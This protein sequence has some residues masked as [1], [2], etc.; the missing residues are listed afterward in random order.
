MERFPAQLERYLSFG[1]SFEAQDRSETFVL[2]WRERDGP[3]VQKP[4][5]SGFGSTVLRRMSERSLNADVELNYL[6]AGLLWR[7]ECPL[8][9]GVHRKQI[10]E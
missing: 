9:S 7:L 3:P 8:G 5:R 2:E 4:T 1:T 6:P 10:L